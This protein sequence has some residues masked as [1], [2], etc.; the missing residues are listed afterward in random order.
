MNYFPYAYQVLPEKERTQ[1]SVCAC[2][3]VDR[4][5]SLQHLCKRLCVA[6]SSYEDSFAASIRAQNSCKVVRIENRFPPLYIP[7]SDLPR[8][9]RNVQASY[10]HAMLLPYPEVF[11]FWRAQSASQILHKPE[12]LYT[13]LQSVADGCACPQHINRNKGVCLLEIT[14]RCSYVHFITDLSVFK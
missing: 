5:I 1:S 7:F 2:Y 8:R 4:T 11:S 6:E 13:A 12:A 9:I 14:Y 3:E 10:L